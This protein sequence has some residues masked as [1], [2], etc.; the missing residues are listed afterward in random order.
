MFPYKIGFIYYDLGYR[1][2][3][4]ESYYNI[5]DFILFLAVKSVKSVSISDILTSDKIWCFHK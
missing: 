2:Y 5:E 3:S 1:V 4:Y